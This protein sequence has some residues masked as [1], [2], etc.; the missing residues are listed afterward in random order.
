MYTFSFIGENIPEDVKCTHSATKIRVFKGSYKG[1]VG[2]NGPNKYV[3]VFGIVVMWV[4]LKGS[5]I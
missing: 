4:P 3:L 5:R 2:S 1:S